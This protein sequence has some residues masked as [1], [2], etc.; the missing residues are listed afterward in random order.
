MVTK[1]A[2]QEEGQWSTNASLR[3]ERRM[4]T[5]HARI[6]KEIGVPK[7]RASP[8]QG[9]WPSQDIGSPAVDVEGRDENCENYD[10]EFK[11]PRCRQPLVWPG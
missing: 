10:L 2:R 9:S 6:E 1:D 4:T 5:G 3:R 7:M 11:G 8:L